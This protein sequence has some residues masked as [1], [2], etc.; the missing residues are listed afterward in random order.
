MKR[1][2]IP[3]LVI[4]SLLL[5]NTS[6]CVDSYAESHVAFY[7]NHVHTGDETRG[8]GCYSSPI[9]H[10]HSPA[11]EG[12]CYTPKYHEHEGTTEVCGGCYTVPVLHYHEGD[13]SSG[14]G[15]Y[16]PRYHQHGDGCYSYGTCEVRT[17]MR[18]RNYYNESCST[19]GDVTFA[20]YEVIES[21]SGCGAERR[22]NVKF[23][24]KCGSNVKDYFVHSYKVLS[25]KTSPGSLE[26]YVLGCNHSEGDVDHYDPGCNMEGTIVG[27]DLTCTKTA[28]DI[29]GYGIG[30]GF[31]EGDPIAAVVIDNDGNG[32]TETVNVT[33]HIEDM[34]GGMVDFSDATF[35]WRDSEGNEIGTTDTVSVS[36]NGT[37]EIEIGLEKPEVDPNS[38]KG[39]VD[40]SNI[41]IPGNDSGGNDDGNGPD[42][43]RNPYDEEYG[44]GSGSDEDGGGDSGGDVNENP[45]ITV[46]PTPTPTPAPIPIIHAPDPGDNNSGSNNDGSLSNLIATAVNKGGDITAPADL[47]VK[48]AFVPAPKADTVEEDNIDIEVMEGNNKEDYSGLAG[49]MH[50]IGDFIKTPAGKIITISA[51]TILLGGLILLLLYLLRNMVIVYNDDTERKRHIMGV[52]RVVLTEE[53]YCID[54]PESISRK[55][56]TNRFAFGMRLF[57]I[58]KDKDTEILVSKDEKRVSAKLC[59]MMEVII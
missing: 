17:E 19:H 54:I 28:A 31:E 29:D 49:L 51:G 44:G 4:I 50:R 3:I 15:C 45:E 20:E 16:V 40:V 57:M 24:P 18:Y 53:G 46:L 11:G 48:E 33:V 2:V 59:P 30:C 9:Y 23:C 43:P 10:T 36:E 38:L 32:H 21:H 34:S 56:Y 7:I 1:R 8:T 26:G 55:A 58:G 13:G 47:V 42:G 14:G 27:Y 52:V 6:F 5:I 35:T 41:H 22:Y 39:E 37:Y 12:D 25:C